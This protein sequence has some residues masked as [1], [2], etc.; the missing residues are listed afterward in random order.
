MSF[1]RPARRSAGTNAWIL[2]I[3][4]SV[5]LLIGLIAL[6]Y[7][8]Y[9]IEN[10][11]TYQAINERKF[12]A[13]PA[14]VAPRIAEPPSEGS[15]IGR[16]QIPRL[17]LRVIVVQGDSPQILKRAVGHLPDTMLPGE[18]GNMALAGHRDTFF[19]PLRGVRPGDLITFET[20]SSAFEYQVEWTHVVPPTSIEVLRS[21][22]ARELTLITCFP[23][24]F[25]GSAPNR[26][27]VRAR[28]VSEAPR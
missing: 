22:G 10:A 5:L 9:V 17:G 28:Q 4:S 8:G 24:D 26:F 15:P 1:V 19:R 27:V 6:G 2:R 25:V 18:D 3:A 13:P 12:E 23:F 14:S 7:A 11:R 21:S 16:L 20:P